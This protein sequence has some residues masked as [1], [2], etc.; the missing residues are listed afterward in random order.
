MQTHVLAA[1]AFGFEL[2]IGLRKELHIVGTVPFSGPVKLVL[3]GHGCPPHGVLRIRVAVEDFIR[4]DIV[5][6]LVRC[7]VI[8]AEFGAE[9]GVITGEVTR[10][11]Q[12]SGITLL[13]EGMVFVHL[14]QHVEIIILIVDGRVTQFL[15]IIPADNISAGAGLVVEPDAV[16]SDP[17]REEI[18]P[19]P[20]I[21]EL[22][23][24]IISQP[25]IP[26]Q[27]IR[28]VLLQIRV[29][30]Q[31]HPVFQNRGEILTGGHKIRQI[32]AGQSGRII[33]RRQIN[34]PDLYT[35]QIRKIL[36][37][38]QIFIIA[39]AGT[40]KVIA[41]RQDNPLLR[42]G[43]TG[44]ERQ[45]QQYRQHKRQDSSQTA[46]PFPE[47]CQAPSAVLFIVFLWCQ[48]PL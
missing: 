29:G 26:L 31:R 10:A 33:L 17:G 12:I 36:P 15:V 23:E 22:F 7:P 4:E 18:K 34:I 5:L 3:P 42:R 39:A 24:H 43:R 30:I 13:R 41:D 20:F 1:G 48:A 38:T 32:P 8:K 44:Q 16:V 6:I 25:G 27:Q 19:I 46:S 14:L 35:H 47:R 9:S 37:H 2:L 11:V 40:V 21:P 45:N 28:T